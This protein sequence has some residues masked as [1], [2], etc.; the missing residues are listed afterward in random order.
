M[1]DIIHVQ[2]V[3]MP[4]VPKPSQEGEF[5]KALSANPKTIA[6]RERRAR[7]KLEATAQ[8]KSV[9]KKDTA[10]KKE[11]SEAVIAQPK[12]NH[13]AELKELATQN[14]GLSPDDIRMECLQR[15]LTKKTASNY[16]CYLRRDG[17]VK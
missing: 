12:S 1:S 6:E 2:E 9:S 3:A 16:V 5:K 17:L 10:S 11:Q 15:N 4:A 7:K 13:Y 8:S 14:S